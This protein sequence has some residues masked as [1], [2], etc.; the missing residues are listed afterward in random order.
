[1]KDWMFFPLMIGIVGAMV[2]TALYWGGAPEPVNPDEGYVVSGTELQYL[3]PSPG[4]YS[5]FVGLDH[6]VMSADS[7]SEQK[8]SQG[9]FTT[10]GPAY[11]RAYQGRNLELTVRVRAGDTNPSDKVQIAFL[12]VPPV[13]GRFGWREFSLEAEYKDIIIPVTLAEFDQAAMAAAGVKDPVI[14]FGIWPDP[15]GKK[16]T[17]H[18]ERYQ[19]MP[20]T[21]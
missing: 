3:T 20:V 2:Y 4:T 15:E 10:L 16:R 13:K 7:R 8:P 12:T 1:M 14:Y 19:V 9:V 11:A 5:E 6:A 18:V 21:E 17:I